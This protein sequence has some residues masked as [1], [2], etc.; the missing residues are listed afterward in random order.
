M[1]MRKKT[2]YTHPQVRAPA[3]FWTKSICCVEGILEQEDKSEHQTR[4]YSQ[5]ADIE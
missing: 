5:H 2:T 3:M 1:Q 4:V